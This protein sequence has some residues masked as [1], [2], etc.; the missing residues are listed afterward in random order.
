[1]RHRGRPKRPEHQGQAIGLS[2]R[3][4]A[5]S[6]S[7]DAPVRDQGPSH[8][9]DRGHREGPQE[10]PEL[11]LPLA[12]LHD[13]ALWCSLGFHL[14]DGRSQPP[15]HGHPG[16]RRQLPGRLPLHRQGSGLALW[17]PTEAPDVRRP[18][19][20]SRAVNLLQLRGQLRTLRHRLGLRLHRAGPQQHRSWAR[21]QTRR[22]ALR[23]SPTKVRQR[24][25]KDGALRG[26]PGH[27]VSER[28]A[29]ALH[30]IALSPNRP[31]TLTA[32]SA[33]GG[34]SSRAAAATRSDPVPRTGATQRLPEH[35][36]PSL[37]RWFDGHMPAKRLG[38]Y[39]HTVI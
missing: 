3:A 9:R 2:A 24:F 13:F 7:E 16:V 25:D 10:P 33:Q 15:D 27:R 22:L 11:V 12:K 30:S 34:L 5:F 20:P 1:M 18:P 31:H 32:R 29:Q 26:R 37:R 17:C 28:H 36:C 4:P 6:M 39:D 21:L 23:C 19:A 38:H 8:Q 35:P 14:P